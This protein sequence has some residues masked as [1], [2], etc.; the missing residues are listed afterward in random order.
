MIFLDNDAV[1]VND[2]DRNEIISAFPVICDI[3]D[4]EIAESVIK[5][6]A[7]CWKMSEYSHLTEIPEFDD[8]NSQGSIVKHTL[9]VTL[10][11]IGALDAFTEEYGLPI[12]RDYVIAAALIHDV[13]KFLC[14]ELDG[15]RKRVPSSFGK[16]VPHGCFGTSAAIE[17]GLPLEIAQI[18][19]SH[20]WHSSR[21]HSGTPEG[22]LV[23]YIN[24]GIKHATNVET[25]VPIGAKTGYGG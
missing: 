21:V 2:A 9:A 16:V 24:K 15:D 18:A 8:S 3:R 25:N 14:Y 7:R 1:E 20:S 13:D 4:K 12:N 5:T 17:S 23:E 10:A 6:W 19:S 22:I 11:S